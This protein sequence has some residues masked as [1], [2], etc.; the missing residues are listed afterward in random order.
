MSLWAATEITCR[1]FYQV[2]F[3]QLPKKQHE[4]LY[5][6]VEDVLK[7]GVPTLA[8]TRYGAT[9]VSEFDFIQS[10]FRIHK[11]PNGDIGL[12][13]ARNGQVLADLAIAVG[14]FECALTA[15]KLGHSTLTPSEKQKALRGAFAKYVEE[16]LE[17]KI[18]QTSEQDRKYAKD[19][20]GLSARAATEVR[21]EA[22]RRKGFG[23]ML[24]GGRRKLTQRFGS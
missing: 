23:H 3:D 18:F 16:N 19:A 7:L 15:Y 11:K 5:R 12:H 13:L 1:V 24:R 21:G 8:W 6:K 4:A 22:Y 14:E 9:E 2:S 10:P 20:L 17:N